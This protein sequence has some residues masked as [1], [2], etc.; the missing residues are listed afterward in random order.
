MESQFVCSCQGHLG[1]KEFKQ[2]CTNI[3]GVNLVSLYSGLGGAE[4]SLGA[5][6]AAVTT[7]LQHMHQRGKC[8]DIKCPA[9]PTFLLACDIDTSCQTVLKQHEHPPAYIVNSIL[10]LITADACSKC[11]RLVEK[12]KQKMRNLVDDTKKNKKNKG[13][14]EFE[15][16]QQ[17]LSL[18]FGE[19]A[20]YRRRRLST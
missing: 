12:A 19:I 5:M 9:P 2:L 4:L 6:H 17:F 3:D 11:E 14:K 10:D 1:E 13:S 8:L 7:E 16:K 20:L 18:V 15:K